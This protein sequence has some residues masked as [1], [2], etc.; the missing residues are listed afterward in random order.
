MQRVW[1]PNFLIYFLEQALIFLY[2]ELPVA[3]FFQLV[4]LCKTFF[5]F[6]AENV[7]FS[8]GTADTDLLA[9]LIEK[10]KPKVSS[11]KL[12]EIESGG[13]WNRRLHVVQR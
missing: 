7:F 13:F 9:K 12:R 6:F 2:I 8:F 10:Q 5:V 3:K 1:L 11:K 4:G